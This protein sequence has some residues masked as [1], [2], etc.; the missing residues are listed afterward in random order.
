MR[1]GIP[2]WYFIKG[3]KVSKYPYL[4]EEIFYDNKIH[5][6]VPYRRYGYSNKVEF[7]EENQGL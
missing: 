2:H 6:N 3:D 4:N 5:Q 1:Y 7:E